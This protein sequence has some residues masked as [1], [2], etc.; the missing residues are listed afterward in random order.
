MIRAHTP[1]PRRPSAEPLLLDAMLRILRGRLPLTRERIVKLVRAE[2]G[3]A[4]VDIRMML[5]PPYFKLVDR[6]WV[7]TWRIG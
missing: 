3:A 6:G 7:C 5:C 1:L 4:A 2:T